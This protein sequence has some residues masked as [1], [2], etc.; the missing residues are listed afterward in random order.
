MAKYLISFLLTCLFSIAPL[1]AANKTAAAPDP[2]SFGSNTAPIMIEEFSD[3]QCPA[4]RELYLETIKKVMTDY[5]S[6]GKV[7]L[8]MHDFPL[9]AHAY[10]KLAA[11]YANAAAKVNKFETVSNELFQ[12]QSVWAPTGNI[13]AIVAAVLTPVEMTKLR[14]ALKDPAIDQGIAAD[15]ALGTKAG[16][17]QTPTMIITRNLRTYPMSGV[18]S[19]PILKRFLDDL[20]TK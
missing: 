20:L 17:R 9:P 14:Q 7:Y 12:K 8:V 13:D 11:Q 1:P 16:L 6:T 4:C 19:Y 5:V 2:K 10:S 15:I 3:Y 18:I